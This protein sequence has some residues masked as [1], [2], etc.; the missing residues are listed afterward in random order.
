MARRA[1][2]ERADRRLRRSRASPSTSRA[3]RRRTWAIGRPSP[4]RCATRATSRSRSPVVRDD[5]CA[6]RL[7]RCPTGRARS[8][9]ATRGPTSC[10]TTIADAMGDALVNVGTACATWKNP[11]GPDPE[12]CDDDM[13][14]TAIPKPAI[15]LDKT[16]G[17]RRGRGLD[18]LLLLHGHQ[19][20]QRARSRGVVLSDP[21]CVGHAAA[22]RAR[23]GGCDVRPGRLLALH[24]HGDR[25]RRPRPGRQPRRGLRLALRARRPARR[26]SATTTRTRSRCRRPARIRPSTSRR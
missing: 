6:P 21:K 9:P 10:T 16:G 5:K 8:I 4:T 20:G 18:L 17:D 7:R 13:H 12:V 25:A 15:L 1:G 22:R 24:V 11:D 3:R 23:S 19:H 2:Q 14:T 26:P